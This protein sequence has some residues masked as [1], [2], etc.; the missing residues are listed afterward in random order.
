MGA[1]GEGLVA[2]AVLFGVALY[3][4]SI[5]L[6]HRV[7]ARLAGPREARLAGALVALGGPVVWSF[8]YGSDIDVI[9]LNLLGPTGCDG[10]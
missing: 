8:L 7:A 2:F 3:L 6:A 10:K 5:L 1:Q 4:G 9:S